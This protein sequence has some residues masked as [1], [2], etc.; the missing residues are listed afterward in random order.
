[1]KKVFVAFLTLLAILVLKSDLGQGFNCD[2]AKQKI[3]PCLSYL[4]GEGGNAP[5]IP[6]C[7]GIN[8][9]KKSTPTKED[10]FAACECLKNST[11]T[12]PGIKDDLVASLPKQCGLEIGFT[13][14]KEI[15]C[16]SIP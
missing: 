13:I 9:M 6:C 15:N 16:Q 8:E 10:R 11:S 2:D 14:S 3:S 7:N 1:M 5:S 4:I 12:V